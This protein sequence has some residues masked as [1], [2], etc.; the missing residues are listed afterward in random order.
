MKMRPLLVLLIA[1]ALP[2]VCVAASGPTI[3]LPTATH[4]SAGTGPMAGTQVAVLFGNPAKRGPFTLRLKVPNGL[5]LLSHFH[6]GTERVTIISGTFLVGLGDKFAPSK[7]TALP[8]G[9]YVVVPAGLHHYAMAKGEAVIQIDG[10]GPMSM[11]PV[12]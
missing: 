4:W 8:A 12:K 9:T 11:S 1:L 7:M 6:G 5:K 10:M 2:A 3:T